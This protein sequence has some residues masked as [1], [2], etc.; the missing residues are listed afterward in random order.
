MSGKL[1][2]C[3]KVTILSESY[4][5]ITKKEKV[6]DQIVR[7]LWASLIW[8]FDTKLNKQNRNIQLGVLHSLDDLWEKKVLLLLS[9][10]KRPALAIS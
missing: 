9:N 4:E 7:V 2:N 5:K 3:W 6:R 1:R 10:V 8:N